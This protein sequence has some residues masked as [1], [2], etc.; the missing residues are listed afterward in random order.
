VPRDDAKWSIRANGKVTRRATALG[1]LHDHQPIHYLEWAKRHDRIQTFPEAAGACA[2]A[3]GEWERAT[4]TSGLGQAV[5]IARENETR[6][7][8]NHHARELRRAQ[9]Q[10]GEKRAYGAL[11]VA[12]GS[13][14]RTS[15]ERPMGKP[16]HN[17]VVDATNNETLSTLLWF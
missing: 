7:T 4:A 12:V 15:A 16:F 11:R 6:A 14:S 17:Q 3:L 2:Q 8:L 10:L 1:A 5:M 13:R 9:G